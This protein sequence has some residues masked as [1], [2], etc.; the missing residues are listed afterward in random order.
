M[1][2]LRLGVGITERQ[3]FP[4]L[5]ARFHG[6]DDELTR[7]AVDGFG[8]R[9]RPL[10]DRFQWFA[11]GRRRFRRW[12]R[13]RLRCGLLRRFGCRFSRWRRSVA[14]RCCV[15]RFRRR[16]VDL[17]RGALAVGRRR[18]LGL[19]VGIGAFAQPQVHGRDPAGGVHLRHQAR[20]GAVD[21]KNTRDSFHEAAIGLPSYRPFS[22]QHNPINS[23][24]FSFKFIG[25]INLIVR[26]AHS[27]RRDS[28]FLNMRSRIVLYPTPPAND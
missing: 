28:K 12:F 21:L 11:L 8:D 7:G 1:L 2:S 22:G 20:F 19:D 13:C 17:G 6:L 4:L 18:R 27:E 14:G 9:R 16:S 23:L 15:H 10:D 25:P 5:V 24:I 3:T 26:L